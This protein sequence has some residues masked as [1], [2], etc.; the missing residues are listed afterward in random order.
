MDVSRED[1]IALVTQ[2]WQVLFGEELCEVEPGD[3][4]K[5]AIHSVV[6][7]RGAWNG[8]CEIVFTEPGA[9]RVACRLL[10]ATIGELAEPE[11]LDAAAEMANIL[12]GNLKAI[13]AQPSS[14]G[15]P[16]VT[17]IHGSGVTPSASV[18]NALLVDFQWDDTQ[19]RVRIV[20]TTDAVGG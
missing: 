7:I 17:K 13:L 3:P 2:S 18:E 11:I 12:A 10:E 19:F 8:R 6:E 5:H 4:E 15:L 14:L 16:H 20:E 1:L 9:E